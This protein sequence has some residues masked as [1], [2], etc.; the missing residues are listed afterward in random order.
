MFS[1]NDYYEHEFFKVKA[2]AQRFSDIEFE[3]CQFIEC[4]FSHSQFSNCRFIDCEFINCN[5]C[6]LS[7]NYSSLEEVSF[8]GCKLNSIV[9]GQVNWPQLAL[10]APVSFKDCEL[11]HSSFFELSLKALTM[12]DCFAKDVDFR[13][14][15]LGKSQFIGTDFRDS[16]FHQTNL[17]NANFVG[18]TQFNIDIKNNDVSGAKFERFEALN[19]L[20]GLDIEL[21]D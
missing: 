16:V 14:A 13:H 18:A 2:T 4:D 15:N 21:V 17:S 3:Q 20:S 11:S 1:Q 10:T 19:L 6:D 8:K 9:W 12:T 5:L 7:W